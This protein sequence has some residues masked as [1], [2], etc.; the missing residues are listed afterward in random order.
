MMVTQKLG[1]VTPEL[2]LQEDR[3]E[4]FTQQ[5]PGT[6][7]TCWGQGMEAIDKILKSLGSGLQTIPHQHVC[8]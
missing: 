1:S 3:T 6:V 7:T 2:P 8:L 5:Q 4:N